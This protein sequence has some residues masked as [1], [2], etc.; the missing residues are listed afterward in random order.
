MTGTRGS[1]TLVWSWSYSSRNRV[2]EVMV[3][4][5]R[6]TASLEGEEDEEEDERGEEK[7]GKCMEYRSTA[8]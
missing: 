8:R 6:I 2:D 3:V 1:V 7:K 4:V 5:S